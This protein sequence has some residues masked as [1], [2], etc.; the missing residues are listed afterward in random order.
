LA[1]GG[2]VGEVLFV[3]GGAP[4]PPPG[5]LVHAGGRKPVI[6]EQAHGGVNKALPCLAALL[7]AKIHCRTAARQEVLPAAAES[8]GAAVQ[9]SIP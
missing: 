3:G 5:N 7:L 9:M 4:P 2:F 6:Q 8:E 1:L